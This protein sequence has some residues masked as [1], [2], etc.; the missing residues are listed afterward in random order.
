LNCSLSLVLAGLLSSA[1][2][3]LAHEAS[4]HVDPGGSAVALLFG[5][6]SIVRFLAISWAAIFLQIL[7]GI[8]NIER[9]TPFD[10]PP[11]FWNL[12]PLSEI[13]FGRSGTLFMAAKHG[14]VLVA[15]ALM[16]ICTVR[17]RNG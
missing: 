12:E 1:I 14:L 15:I 9:W 17:H 8:A 10:I 5:P 11:Y 7:S 6:V 13:R 2:P 16:M 4:P 3:A